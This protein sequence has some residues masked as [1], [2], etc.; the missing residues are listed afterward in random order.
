MKPSDFG[1]KLLGQ[2][3]YF[4]HNFSKHTFPYRVLKTCSALSNMLSSI[5]QKREEKEDPRG[6]SPARVTFSFEKEESSFYKIMKS[7]NCKSKK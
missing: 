4:W 6:E 7:N 1:S 5:Q 3:R 2:I